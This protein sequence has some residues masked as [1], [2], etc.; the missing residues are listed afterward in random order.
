MLISRRHFLALVGS[1][2]AV[3]AACGGDDTTSGPA[4]GGGQ[5][6]AGGQGGVGGSG[7]QA[8]SGSGGGPPDPNSFIEPTDVTNKILWLQGSACSGCSISLLNRLSEEAPA[9]IEDTL[10]EVVVLAYH[11]T[12]MVAAGELAISAAEALYQEGDYLLVVEG[13]IPTAFGGGAC[14]GWV[15]EGEEITFAA[16]V[17]RFAERAAAI[18]C[19]GTC[20]SW[21][22][23]AAAEPNP[24]A[25]V[26]TKELTG[27]TTLN[28]SGCPA[29]PDWIVWG[30]SQLLDHQRIEIDPYGRP[31]E[32]YDIRLHDRC[33]RLLAQEADTPGQEGRCS[34]TIGCRGQICWGPCA[35]TPWNNG[36]SW[37]VDAN[38]PCIGCTEPDF[39]QRG[40]TEAAWEGE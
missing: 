2:A 14:P 22:G 16:A 38:A 8:G 37:C 25:V 19:V 40:F 32:L 18:V 33:P 5:G 24:C 9:T 10:L 15:V 30:I 1:S 34:R 36:A 20:A 11:P 4:G 28:I 12:L 17:E 39:P 7:G 3:A 29:H 13:G 6:A 31:Y 27:R 21:G 35:V 26:G 23:I